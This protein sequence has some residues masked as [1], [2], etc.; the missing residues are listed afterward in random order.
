MLQAHQPA[1]LYGL[2]P[3]ALTLPCSW[4]QAL[5]CP[6]FRFPAD[7]QMLRLQ[8]ALRQGL[9]KPV[10]E[11]STRYA[12]EG[13]RMAQGLHE[14]SCCLDMARINRCGRVPISAP[15]LRCCCKQVC[16]AASC[17][18]GGGA[19]MCCPASGHQHGDCP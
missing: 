9:R 15:P 17:E 1:V 14:V 11:G 12:A 16:H 6:F 18:G 7:S 13:P 2:P 3:H 8:R 19:L 10:I 4:V 5:T